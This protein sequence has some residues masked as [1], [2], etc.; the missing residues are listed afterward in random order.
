MA[1]LGGLGSYRGRAGERMQGEPSQQQPLDGNSNVGTMSRKETLLER[2]HQRGSTD[3]GHPVAAPPEISALN[4]LLL[5][6]N[7]ILHYR[8]DQRSMI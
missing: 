5:K 2:S 4:H 3:G 1:V 6:N 7:S 8:K